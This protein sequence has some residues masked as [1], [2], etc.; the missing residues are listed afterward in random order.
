[1][2]RSAVHEDLM[3]G[4]RSMSVYGL[5]EKEEILIMENGEWKI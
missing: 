1:M 2:N 5:L 4:D 3:F